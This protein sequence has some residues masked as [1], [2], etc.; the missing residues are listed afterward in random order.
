MHKI[1]LFLN[2]KRK[3]KRK[4]G[5]LLRLSCDLH[6]CTPVL[7]HIYTYTPTHM[8]THAYTH[9]LKSRRKIRHL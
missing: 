3:W 4:V 5:S 6:T 8:Y 9:T 1:I 2:K 7:M